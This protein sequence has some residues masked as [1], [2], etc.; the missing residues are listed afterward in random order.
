M[1]PS[2]ARLCPTS[3]IR[4]SPMSTTDVNSGTVLD[5]P[6]A[7]TVQYKLAV[8]VLPVSDVDRAKQFYTGLGWR[9]AADS[10]IREGFRVVQLTPPGSPTSVIFGSGVTAAEPGSYE[11]LVLAVYDI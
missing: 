2:A 11:G 3:Q 9:E 5:A 6:E 7:G 1:R 4:R 8:M 10:P